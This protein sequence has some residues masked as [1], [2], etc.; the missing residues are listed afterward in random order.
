[1]HVGNNVAVAM[2]TDNCEDCTVGIPY[3]YTDLWIPYIVCK[4][5][6]TCKQQITHCK[7]RQA[8][9]RER[10]QRHIITFRCS[11]DTCKYQV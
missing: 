1:M 11:I 6:K 10:Q 9:S 4:S 8:I 2:Q 5:M 7:L 3:M